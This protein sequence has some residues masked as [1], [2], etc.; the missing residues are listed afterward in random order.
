MDKQDIS[1]QLLQRRPDML[2]S[3]IDDEV[4][5]MSIESG[6]YYGLNPIASKIWELL[7]KPHTTVQLVELLMQEFDVDEQTCREDV[8]Q[9]LRQMLQKNLITV[10][11]QPSEQ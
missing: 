8:L 10:V 3:H 7:E 1:R 4:V 5:M 2:F 11:C 6:E 9:F